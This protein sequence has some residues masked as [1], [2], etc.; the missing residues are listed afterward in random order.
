M[1]DALTLSVVG[2]YLLE[3]GMGLD[4]R[5]KSRSLFHVQALNI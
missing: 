5:S 1:E 2:D 4:I 3:F